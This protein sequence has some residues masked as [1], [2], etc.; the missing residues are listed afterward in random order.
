MSSLDN[1]RKAARRWLRQLRAGD[2]SARERLRRALPAAP[3]QATLRDVQHALAREHGLDGWTALKKKALARQADDVSSLDAALS[4][5]LEGAGR[6]DVARVIELADAFPG[7][8]SRRGTLEGDDGR[9]TALHFGVAH[10]PVVRA[11]LQR[12]ADPNVRDDGDNAF[13]LHFAAENQDLPVIR[14]LVEH[15][16]DPIGAGDGHE[17]EVIGWSCCWDYREATKEIVDYLLANGARH[18]I[19]S[20]VAMGEADLIRTLANESPDSLTRRMDRT[21]KRRT[22]LHLAVVKKQIGA[23]SALLD[24]GADTEAD[25][26]AGL[27][28]LDQAALQGSGAIAELLIDRGARI[29]LPAA[30]GLQRTADIERLIR[31]EPGALM[32][33][34][35]FATLIVRAAGTSGADVVATLIR[36]GADVNISDDEATAVDQSRGYTP[37]H[38][39]AWQANEEVVR[40]LMKHG[41]DVNARE[42]KYGSTP[43]GWADYAGRRHIRDLILRGPIDI[44]Q[45]IDFDRVEHIPQLL[46][47]DREALNRPFRGFSP[48]GWAAARKNVEATRLLLAQGA[49]LVMPEHARA[50]MENDPAAAGILTILTTRTASPASLP[51]GTHAERV[52][53]FLQFACWDHHTH[54]K[55]DHRMYDRAAQRLLEQHPALA[56]D[57]LYTAIVCGD[58]E[59]V[60]RRLAERP[61]AACERGGP[62]EWTPLLYACYARFSSPPAIEHAAAIA[63][64]LL[65]RD[66]NPNDYYMAG[67]S[68]YSA[69]TGVAREGEQDAPPHPRREDL[70][71]LLLERGANPYDIQVLYDTHFSG[72]VLWWLRLVY[73]HAVK[74]G[75]TSDWAD[76]DWPM[77]DMGGYGSGAR[78]LLGIAIRKN[79]IALARWLL[80]H[81]ANPD[82]VP[83]RNAR[84]SERTLYEEAVREG[85][86]GIAELLRRHGATPTVAAMAG[87]EA[88]IDA[89]LRLD[90]P[91]IEAQ[92]RVHPEYLQSPHAMFEAAKRNRSDAVRLLIDVG[93]PIDVRD[94]HN[95]RALHHAAAEG[96]IAVAQLLIQG[97][98]EIDPRES[99]YG[100]TPIGWAAHSDRQE[101]L[102]VLSRHSRDVW[103]LA[104]R[105]YVDRLRDVLRER[106][107][108][109]RLTDDEGSTPLWWLPDDEDQALEVVDLLIAHGADP[110][111]RNTS[112]RT[113]AD[114]ARARGMLEVADRLGR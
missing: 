60:T 15:G 46:K 23:V 10:E 29:R 30:V 51:P 35:R 24:L 111:A 85:A 92:L 57:S 73:A 84:L 63:G 1:L 64:L 89:C 34:H 4:A 94:E 55:G 109:A 97:G 102:D 27:T 61:E 78:F 9:R 91:A 82:A 49:A 8:V 6:G 47:T 66:A 76:P 114:W 71:Q 95:T 110:L 108:L 50:Q 33:G 80:E 72:D 56:R 67:H 101:M 43:A 25:D 42:E 26:A 44:I 36:L 79:D 69:L 13:P 28:P 2:A 90:R 106:P 38:A 103:T 16:A 100:A 70:F 19:F 12:G 59:E 113:A 99:R 105:G 74:T 83:A 37:L 22:A 52:A 81:G 58:L 45:A 11:L 107:D 14:L 112:G 17:L 77:F 53:R 32:P 96:A 5:L 87:E 75:H 48:L 21:N 20:A 65:D 104:F 18:H 93:A 41:A 54:G 40:T 7:I 31:D 98:A 62:R 3:V 68:R 88:F 86:T 39:A